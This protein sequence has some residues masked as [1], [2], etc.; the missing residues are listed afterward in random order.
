MKVFTSLGKFTTNEIMPLFVAF[1]FIGMPLHT[2]V[3]ALGEQVLRSLSFG[4]P[5]ATAET[6]TY[7]VPI[8][9]IN[10]G[11]AMNAV[12]ITVSYN[13]E[14]LVVTGITHEAALCEDRFLIHKDID[15]VHGLVHYTCGTVTPFT[16]TEVTLATLTVRP[17]ATSTKLTLLH[18][19][20]IRMHDGFGTNAE[21]LLYAAVLEFPFVD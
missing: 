8:I 14:E 17:E 5:V 18:D 19:S 2:G 20:S 7:E 15:S 9:F 12:D 10:D 21:A 4:T 11:T 6:N 1:A 16:G 3:A 13:P